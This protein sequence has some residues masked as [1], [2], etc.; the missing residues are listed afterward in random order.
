MRTNYRKAKKGEVPCCRCSHA[1]PPFILIGH[2]GTGGRRWRCKLVGSYHP[3]V[4]ANHTCNSIATTTSL[5]KVSKTSR[6]LK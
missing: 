3:V 5:M 4:G 1:V 6:I 2:S